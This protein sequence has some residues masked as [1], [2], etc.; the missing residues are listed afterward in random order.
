MRRATSRFSPFDR[1][2]QPWDPM[3]LLLQGH[4]KSHQHKNKPYITTR[5]EQMKLT[6]LGAT[7]AWGIQTSTQHVC[8]LRVLRN[9]AHLRSNDVRDVSFLMAEDRAIAPVSSNLLSLHKSQRITKELGA[10]EAATL[11]RKMR[12]ER[13]SR[14]WAL[15]G[16][17]DS[18]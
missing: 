3:L 1:A 7:E 4:A 17:E 16:I 12:Y 10:T 2:V 18:E 14:I 8:D 13:R 5:M 11:V 15:P 6:E 9:H